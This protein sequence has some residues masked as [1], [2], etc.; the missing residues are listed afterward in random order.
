MYIFKIVIFIVL[1]EA[2]CGWRTFWKG[3]RLN[4]NIGDPTHFKKSVDHGDG[5]EDLWFTQKLD[6]SQPMNTQTWKQVRNRFN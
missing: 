5:S 3:R 6:H 1:A 2:A 4:G